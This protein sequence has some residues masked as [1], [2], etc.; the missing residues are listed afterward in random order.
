MRD[1]LELKDELFKNGWVVKPQLLPKAGDPH[2][3]QKNN[4]IIWL[5][6]KGWACAELIDNHFCNHR[7]YP[8]LSDAMKAE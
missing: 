1:D 7:Y 8:W 4:K 3:F 6:Q 5:C 2:S